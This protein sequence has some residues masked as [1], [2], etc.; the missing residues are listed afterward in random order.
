MAFAFNS[1]NALL[2]IQMKWNDNVTA[3]AFVRME[4]RIL[5]IG[6]RRL[7][8]TNT[9]KCNKQRHHVVCV[10][11][12]RGRVLLRNFEI[13]KFESGFLQNGVAH[14][15]IVLHAHVNR[16]AASLPFAP[17]FSFQLKLE[18]RHEFMSCVFERNGRNE[19]ARVQIGERTMINFEPRNY[20]AASAGALDTTIE[21]I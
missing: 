18:F 10:Y 1:T 7:V 12:V 15:R 5:F 20:T 17:A 11:V 8:P 6:E 19:G 14:T 3:V 13:I 2:N 16:Q 4:F 21:P 9:K